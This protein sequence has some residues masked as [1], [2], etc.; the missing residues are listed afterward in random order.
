M[1]AKY[2]VKDYLSHRSVK[3]NIIPT[4]MC[5]NHHD[6]IINMDDWEK[7]QHRLS[8]W[9]TFRYGQ[10]SAKAK[11]FTA[12]DFFPRIKSGPL[13]GYYL[14]DLGWT[15]SQRKQFLASVVNTKLKNND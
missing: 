1:M 10:K 12:T 13:R 6:P 8:N 2:I 11:K 5:E 7:A 4:I 15:R 9:R 3:N 14:L